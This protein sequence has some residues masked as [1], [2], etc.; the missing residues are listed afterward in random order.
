MISFGVR[1]YR[2]NTLDYRQIM[3]QKKERG[4]ISIR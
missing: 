2:K 3:T 1:D 4:A